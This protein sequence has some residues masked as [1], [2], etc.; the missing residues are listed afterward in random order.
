MYISNVQGR[1]LFVA[2]KFFFENYK[3]NSTAYLNAFASNNDGPA[4]EHLK[5]ALLEQLQSL[6]VGEIVQRLVQE[7]D[8]A[9]RV[10]RPGET[11]FLA[12]R[13]TQPGG[14]HLGVVE[15][16]QRRYV[17]VQVRRAYRSVVSGKSDRKKKG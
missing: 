16:H 13:R 1:F 11:D 15:L 4:R 17:G 14:G 3:I 10:N 7:V 2:L 5:D 12:L 8:V 9:L 6:Q